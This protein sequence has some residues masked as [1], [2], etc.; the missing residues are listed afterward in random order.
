MPYRGT[1]GIEPHVMDT[2]PHFHVKFR[3]VE[4]E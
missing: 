3:C 1:I 4:F 2:F